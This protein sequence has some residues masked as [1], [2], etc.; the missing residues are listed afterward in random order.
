MAI[1]KPMLP[2]NLPITQQPHHQ[3]QQIKVSDKQPHYLLKQF[4]KLKILSIFYKF[5]YI[6][7]KCRLYCYFINECRSD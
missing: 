6:Q 1:L 5:V 3:L 2:V 7:I 4:K